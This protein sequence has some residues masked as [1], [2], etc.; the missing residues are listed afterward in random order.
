MGF[1]KVKYGQCPVCGGKGEDDPSSGTQHSTEDHAGAGYNL[2]YYE[3]RLMCKM[4][5]KRLKNDAE[6]AIKTAAYNE[7]QKFLEKCG[8]RKTME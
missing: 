4:C 3:G 8:V 1:P 2:V 6:T 7:N 5:K